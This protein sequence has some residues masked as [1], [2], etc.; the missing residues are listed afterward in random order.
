MAWYDY[1]PGV[2]VAKKIHGALTDDDG[3]YD[4][5]KGANE[6][7][8]LD[9]QKLGQA[10]QQFYGQAQKNAQGAYQ[11][12]QSAYQSLYGQERPDAQIATGGLY[13][14]ITVPGQKA[15][16]LTKPGAFEMLYDERKN[17]TNEHYNRLRSEGLG[18][19]GASAA[20]RGHFNSGGAAVQEGAFV[21]DLAANEAR[22]MASLA[23]GAQSA[24]ESRLRGGLTSA[25]SL[26]DSTA[27]IEKWGAESQWN[28]LSE[29]EKT[30]MQMQLAAAGVDMQRFRDDQQYQ[31]AILGMVAGVGGAYAGRK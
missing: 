23:S 12:A 30:N 15:G 6:Q 4:K 14:G 21:A 20:A 22:D 7:A 18:A 27:G 31:L 3:A 19:L 16:A 17:G 1:I 13:G 2:Y 10:G 25:Q 28:A 29:G 24:Q 26:G 5:L 8:G 9:A 11:G